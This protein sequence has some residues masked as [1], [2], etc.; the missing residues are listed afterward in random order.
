MKTGSDNGDLI[1]LLA[2]ILHLS[3]EMLMYARE[4]QWDAVVSSE[5]KRST[6][7]FLL[8]AALD[9]ENETQENID[10]YRKTVASVIDSD[11]ELERL[12]GSQM[13]LL[14]KEAGDLDVSR[15]AV[16]AYLDNATP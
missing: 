2:E 15:R 4:Q 7:V 12:A 11:K 3:Q 10:S 1:S 5:N 9:V 6:K 8:E 16:N 13:N 14:S